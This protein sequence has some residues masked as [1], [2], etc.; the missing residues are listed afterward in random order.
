MIQNNCLRES[1]VKFLSILDRQ[2]DLEWFYKGFHNIT[3][4][5][6]S[7]RVTGKIF[8]RDEIRDK[9]P[10]TKS[11]GRGHSIHLVYGMCGGCIFQTVES[12]CKGHLSVIVLVRVFSSILQCQKLK[13][14]LK[15]RTEI[16]CMGG[17]KHSSSYIQRFSKL[18]SILFYCIH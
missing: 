8:Y 9:I 18:S 4:S 1:Q 14:E 13:R 6:P 3:R 10:Q 16:W 5:L 2:S 7:V 17:S 12:R 15:Y 11:G